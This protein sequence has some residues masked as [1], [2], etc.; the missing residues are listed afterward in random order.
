MTLARLTFAPHVP[1]CSVSPLTQQRSATQ[2]KEGEK[3]EGMLARPEETRPGRQVTEMLCERI[4][5][6]QEF[7]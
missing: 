7:T 3:H 4:K 1:I 2:A 5:E 6:R